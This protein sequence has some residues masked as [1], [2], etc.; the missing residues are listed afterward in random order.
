MNEELCFK[1]SP[2][3]FSGV[4]KG[5]LRPYT[6]SFDDK[7][8]DWKW[9]WKPERLPAGVSFFLARIQ[10]EPNFVEV[11]FIPV[12][13]T[14]HYSMIVAHT[15]PGGT[16]LRVS[17][18]PED[19]KK[20]KVFW[21]ALSTELKW[22]GLLETI[23]AEESKSGKQQAQEA[24]LPS[25]SETNNIFRKNGEYWT[26]NYEGLNINIRD[27][28]GLQYIHGLL[29][30]PHKEFHV[31]DLRLAVDGHNV[32]S[33]LTKEELRDQ[34]TSGSLRRLDLGN[35][36]E[37]PDFQA[38]KKYKSRIKELGAELDRPNSSNPEHGLLRKEAERE[39]ELITNELKKGCGKFRPSN[40]IVEKTRKAVT[41]CIKASL[42]KIQKDHKPLYQH[43]S[44]SIKTGAICSYNPEITPCWNL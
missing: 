24:E 7:Y 12:P 32:D 19:W 41:R 6:P 1:G 16:R 11:R 5:F 20:H 14:K 33:T 26:L 15:A 29:S 35:L 13:E 10:D 21:E 23:L 31:Q 43:L 4:V 38:Q 25:L 44:K 30:N 28:K 39:I 9:L 18:A 8:P 34:L 2:T 22:Q 40:D 27:L 3:E 36:E 42:K 37:G 17:K